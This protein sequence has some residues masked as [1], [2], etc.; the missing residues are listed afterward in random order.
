MLDWD[1][2]AYYHRLLLRHLPQHCHKL[3]E[4]GCGSGAFAARIAQRAEHVDA[5][6]RATSMIEAARQRAPSTVTCVRA[7]AVKDPLPGEGYDAIVS[8]SALH[9]MP[10]QEAL[11]R[12]AA[13]LRPGGILAVIALP[14]ADIRRELPIEAVAAGG[15][16]LF[17]A[18]F[19]VARSLGN[20]SWFAQDA[21]H[22]MPVVMDPPLTTHEVYEQASKVLPGVRVRRLVFWRYLLLW[23]KPRDETEIEMDGP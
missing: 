18:I 15:H 20:E 10:L 11:R 19:L 12:L 6:D 21:A 7:D 9:H 16:R 23:Q 14:R 1:H 5:L 4:V 2:N 22:T 17:G 13:A 3:L 8:L